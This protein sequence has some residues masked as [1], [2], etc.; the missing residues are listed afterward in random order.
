MA[1]IR[2]GSA[3]DAAQIAAVQREGWLAAYQGIIPAGII[4]RVTA[5]RRAP[6]SRTLPGSITA[7]ER[8]AA[9]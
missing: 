1:V 5:P 9:G 7:G 4:D 2:A 8:G 6:E 3:A